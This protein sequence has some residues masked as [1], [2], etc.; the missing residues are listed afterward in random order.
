MYCGVEQARLASVVTV[1]AP[2]FQYFQDPIK[3]F[4]VQLVDV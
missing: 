2:F 1:Q 4:P 3:V